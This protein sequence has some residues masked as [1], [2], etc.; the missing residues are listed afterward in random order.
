[1][2]RGGAESRGDSGQE[3]R[4]ALAA[5]FPAAGLRW[6]LQGAGTP[7]L[8]PLS[9]REWESH[10]FN[11]Y[12]LD[13]LLDELA[14]RTAGPFALLLL[15]REDRLVGFA[16]EVLTRCQRLMDR[17]NPASRGELFDRILAGHRALHDLSKPLVRADYNHALDTWHW[18]L[19]LAPEAGLAVQLAALFH[20]VERLV[21]EADA[22]IEHKAADYQ[23]FK[24]DHALRSAWIADQALARAGADAQTRR[25]VGRLIA[26]HERPA[27]ADDPEAGDI[28]LLNDADA[29]SFFSLN[30]VG[31]LD[32]F[33]P[34]QT[35]RKVAYTLRRLSPAARRHLAGIRLRPEVAAALARELGTAAVRERVA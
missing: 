11:F 16:C 4:E 14:E 24:D 30:S 27:A 35:R 19:R 1:M 18:T 23:A 5:E 22:R 8:P 12:E 31:Y 34:E 7:S 33:G 15:A 13:A 21:S 17:R 25:R 10:F 3:A 26:E 32:Y 29:L 28:A 6:T 20:D 9:I 2:F